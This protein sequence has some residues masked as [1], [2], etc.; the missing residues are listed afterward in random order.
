MKEIEE[1]GSVSSKKTQNDKSIIDNAFN[2]DSFDRFD[3]DS[4]LDLNYDNT[5][6]REEAKVHKSLKIPPF[7]EAEDQNK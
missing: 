1:E 7:M 2:Q 5:P 6:G 3:S 4:K